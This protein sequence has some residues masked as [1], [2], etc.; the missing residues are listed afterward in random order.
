MGGIA[1]AIPSSFTQASM[2]IDY[3]RVYQNTLIDTEGPT[4]YSY[5]GGYWFFS[6]VISNAKDNSEISYDVAYGTKNVSFA[7]PSGVQNQRLYLIYHL[8]LAIRLQQLIWL[9]TKRLLIHSS[10]HYN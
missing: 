8:I 5:Q 7:N 10:N 1:G 3:V 2:D 9:E 4:I 6:G